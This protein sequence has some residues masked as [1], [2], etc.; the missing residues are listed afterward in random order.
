MVRPTDWEMTAIE[1]VVCYTHKSQAKGTCY[2]T[3]A[4][5]ARGSTVVRQGEQGKPRREPLLSFLGG[6]VSGV[7]WASW[8]R[9]G[10]GA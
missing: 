7:G 2:A 8:N 3:G 4:G 6:W 9:M 5:R 1:N 10:S